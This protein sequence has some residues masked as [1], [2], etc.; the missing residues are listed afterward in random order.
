MMSMQISSCGNANLCAIA[1]L[2]ELQRRCFIHDGDISGVDADLPQAIAKC[3]DHAH[4]RE[5]INAAT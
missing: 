4:W 2:A 5:G 1:C 3:L